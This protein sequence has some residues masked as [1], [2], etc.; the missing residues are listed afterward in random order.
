MRTHAPARLRL[1]MHV[2]ARTRSEERT[3]RALREPRSGALP[4]RGWK[5]QREEPE[6]S[7]D[8]QARAG[9]LSRRQAASRHARE[10]HEDR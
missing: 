8:E 3:V 6:R 1:L 7:T 5:R 9:T 2:R 4:R 10:A